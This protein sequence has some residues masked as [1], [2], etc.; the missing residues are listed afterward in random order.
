MYFE[1]DSNMLD[2]VQQILRNILLTI[3]TF[4]YWKKWIIHPTA[5]I[6]RLAMRVPQILFTYDWG[7][8]IYKAQEETPRDF[9]YER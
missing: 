1:V 7:W 9:G 2:A 3:V 6:L 8:N 5:I 4:V